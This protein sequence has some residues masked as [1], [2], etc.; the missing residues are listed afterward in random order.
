MYEASEGGNWKSQKSKFSN[1]KAPS[2]PEIRDT[3]S[4]SKEK[5]KILNTCRHLVEKVRHVTML[6]GKNSSLHKALICIY[7][8]LVRVL[9]LLVRDRNVAVTALRKGWAK[10]S[11]NLIKLK[12]IFQDLF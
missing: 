3:V 12:I 6:R 9:F 11:E 1:S 2:I 4:V 7:V 8:F 5:P 10:R